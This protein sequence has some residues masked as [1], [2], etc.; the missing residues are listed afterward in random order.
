MF[1][2]TPAAIGLQLGGVLAVATLTGL[3]CSALALRLWRGDRAVAPLRLSQMLFVAAIVPTMF[4][5][6]VTA[7]WQVFAIAGVELFAAVGAASV[8]P[9]VLQDISPAHLRGR[10]IALSSII[11]ALA[12]GVTPVVIGLISDTI[13]SPRGL[14]IGIGAVALPGWLVA[15]AAMRWAERPYRRT[16]ASFR[17]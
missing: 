14:M 17:S 16:L 5:P 7:P 12:Q 1:D 9:G 13:Q 15:A 10:V 3:L 2:I 8:L 4:L 11:T 6:F